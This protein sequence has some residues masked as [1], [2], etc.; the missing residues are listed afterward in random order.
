MIS[1]LS[2]TLPDDLA[3]IFPQRE[4]LKFKFYV[5]SCL[6]CLILLD[7]YN[8][9]NRFFQVKIR[10]DFSEFVCSKLG[11]IKEVTDYEFEEFCARHLDFYT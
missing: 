5:H 3:L 9:L 11:E 2:A 7:H 6:I 4:I 1:P 8:F 10:T